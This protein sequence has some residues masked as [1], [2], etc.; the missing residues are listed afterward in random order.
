MHIL[1]KSHRFTGES[2]IELKDTIDDLFQMLLSIVA[3][4][5]VPAE[6]RSL[7]ARPRRVASRLRE[8]PKAACVYALSGRAAHSACN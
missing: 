6:L 8:A 5:D 7:A 2:V 1:A 4:D 3:A